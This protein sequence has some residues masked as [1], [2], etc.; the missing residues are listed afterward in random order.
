MSTKYTLEFLKAKLGDHLVELNPHTGNPRL[1]LPNNELW[2]YIEDAGGVSA[3]AKYLG[4]T[5]SMV[6][7]WV[8]D[9]YVPSVFLHEMESM[10]EAD[11]IYLQSPCTGF[12]DEETGSTWPWSW[13]IFVED[14]DFDNALAALRDRQKQE[15]QTKVSFTVKPSSAQLAS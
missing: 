11:R 14:S 4:I 1:T 8:D 7:K 13:K 2:M 9:N 15:G 3:I 10:T 12:I 6:W 5:E